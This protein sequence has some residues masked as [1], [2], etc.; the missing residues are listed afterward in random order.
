MYSVV[1]V[2]VFVL[3]NFRSSDSR[4]ENMRSELDMQTQP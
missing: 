3:Y 1:E 4:L 2:C